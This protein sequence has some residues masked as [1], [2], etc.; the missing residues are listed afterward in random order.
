[1]IGSVCD[2]ALDGWIGYR[3]N[4]VGEKVKQTLFSLFRIIVLV[5]GI[6]TLLLYL[7]QEKM[8]FIRQALWLQDRDRFSRYEITIDHQG[9]RLKG[10]FIKGPVTEKMPLVVYYGGNAEEVSANMATRDRFRTQ[11]FLFMNYRGYGESDGQPTEASLFKDALY[12]L[13]HVTESNQIPLNRVVLMGRSLGSGVA[14]YVAAHRRVKGVILVTPFDSLLNVAKRHYPFFPVK[15][16]LKHRFDSVS[17]APGI[18]LPALFIMGSHDRII[19]NQ[20]TRA[21]MAKWGGPVASLTITGADHNSID[22]SKDYW[23]AI[24]DF[25]DPPE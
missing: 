16:L 11:S 8:I 15:L 6:G 10:W 3:L 13:D 2:S 9:N 14:T 22:F 19:P 25:I 12:I 18:Q 23:A 5:A 24:N 4:S 20:H 17:L 7:F 21:L 1:M